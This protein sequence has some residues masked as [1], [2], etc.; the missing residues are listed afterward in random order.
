MVGT[1]PFTDLALLKVDANRPLPVA[2]LGDSDSDRVRVG[3]WVL[4]V[5]NSFGLEQTVTA[6][7][8]SGK[9]RVLGLGPED[10][11]IQ[12][13][14]PINPGNSGG[15]LFNARGEVVGINSIIFGHTGESVGVGLAIPINLVK[16]LVP[17]LKVHSRITRGSLGIAATPVTAELA[18]KLG[19]STP[20][21]AIVAQVVPNGPA[22]RAGI[23]P[24]D[25]IVAF[26][27]P[28]SL[29]DTAEREP[30]CEL[31]SHGR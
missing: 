19:R 26:A 15:P 4:A 6:G 23:R 8:V 7:I 20:E 28:L 21:G 22:A 16:E 18:R 10:D 24:G 1:D 27:R 30:L 3:D 11:F 12:T 29:D 25:L 17:Q 9:G 2:P 13:D 31:S 14:A 5:G